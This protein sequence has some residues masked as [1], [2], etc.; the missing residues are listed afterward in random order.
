MEDIRNRLVGPLDRLGYHVIEQGYETPYGTV[1]YIA[2]KYAKHVDDMVMFRKTL[3]FMMLAVLDPDD[4]MSRLSEID[5]GRR[6]QFEM[7]ACNY[8]ENAEAGSM[9][10]ANIA[11]CDVELK[12]VGNDKGMLRIC[13]F[14]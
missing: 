3:C 7:I 9:D 1:D 2:W 4:E 12:K 11:F 14:D 13:T 8:L 5:D 10:E 6:N